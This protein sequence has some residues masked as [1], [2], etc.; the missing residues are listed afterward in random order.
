MRTFPV[1]YFQKQR[2]RWRRTPRPVHANIW[3]VKNFI[4]VPVSE[5]LEQAFGVSPVAFPLFLKIGD[6]ECLEVGGNGNEK[7]KASGALLRQQN[8]YLR[9]SSYKTLHPNFPFMQFHNRFHHR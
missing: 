7:A 5:A 3:A 1:P 4:A 2:A 6:G 9:P 8:S